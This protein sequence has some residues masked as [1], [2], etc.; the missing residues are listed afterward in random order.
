MLELNKAWEIYHTADLIHSSQVVTDAVARLAGEISLQFADKQPLVLCVMGGAT[1]FAGQLL[2]LL[3]FPLDFD[4]VQVSRYGD[5]IRGGTMMWKVP[6]PANVKGR[7]VLVLDDILDEGI[8]LAEIRVSVLELGAAACYSAVFADKEIGRPKPIHADFVGLRV[9][10][11][12][13]FGF[14]MDVHGAWRNLPAIYA[15]KEE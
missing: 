13:V 15:L 2:P 6:P 14:G 9:P 5:A 10:D 12:Y 4:Y 8:T 3:T 7:V 1:V 11:R